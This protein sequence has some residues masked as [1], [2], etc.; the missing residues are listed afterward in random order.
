[1]LRKILETATTTGHESC[2]QRYRMIQLIEKIMNAF[3]MEKV[4]P[5]LVCGMPL[6]QIVLQYVTITMYGGIA[7]P[8]F[9]MFPMTMVNAIVN[10]ILIFTLA[11]WVFNSS[12]KSLK[13]LEMRI[14]Q[15]T[16]RSVIR[17]QLKSCGR[18]KI[19]FG[20]NFID[21]GTPLV[22]QDFC[23]NQTMSLILISEGKQI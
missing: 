4:A 1:M 10:N 16:R 20:S 14:L 11:S 15:C 5:S 23:F 13:K 9:L 17:K 12:V 22:I 2:V 18:L 3:L 21:S 6:L 7:M 19:K 8:V